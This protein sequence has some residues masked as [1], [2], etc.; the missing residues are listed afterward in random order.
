MQKIVVGTTPK[1]RW[2]FSNVDVSDIVIA[3]MTGRRELNGHLVY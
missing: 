1:I 2:K 3:T